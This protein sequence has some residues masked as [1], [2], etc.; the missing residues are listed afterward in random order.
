MLKQIIFFGIIGA[1][2][3]FLIVLPVLLILNLE[4]GTSLFIWGGFLVLGAILGG[5]RGMV[6]PAPRCPH[7]RQR[8]NRGATVCHH[9]GREL[10]EA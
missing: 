10:T 4:M 9:C 3:G 6:G 5:I 8:V 2:I 1:G 7:C